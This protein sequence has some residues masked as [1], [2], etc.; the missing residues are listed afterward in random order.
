MVVLAVTADEPIYGRYG[1]LSCVES[2]KRLGGVVLIWGI[3]FSRE[4]APSA[5]SEICAR[6]R[7]S[8]RRPVSTTPSHVGCG[9]VEIRVSWK[10]RKVTS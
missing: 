2:E 1:A 9:L 4:D 10:F 6:S 5:D 7:E 3:E 8:E